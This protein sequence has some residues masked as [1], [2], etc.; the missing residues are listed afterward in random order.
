MK[1]LSI[2]IPCYNEEE[3]IQILFEKIKENVQKL[4][5]SYEVIFVDDG[6]TDQSQIRQIELYQK[7]PDNI[8]LIQ[9]RKNSGKA[10]ALAAGFR[11]AEGKL[12]ITMD[13]DLQDDPAEIKNLIAKINEG[14]DLVSGWK[15]KRHDPISKTL[16]SKIFNFVVSKLSGIKIHDFN[17][18]LKIYR[19]EVVE[20]LVV[21]GEMHRYLPVLAHWQ[22]FKISEIPVQHHPRQYGKSKYGF[23]RFVKG[24]LDLLTVLFLNRYAKR[25]LH[26]FG[27]IGIIL[28]ILGLFINVYIVSL[29][30][31]FGNIQNRHPL[32][33]LGILLMIISIQFISTGLLG[34]MFVKMYLTD[35]SKFPLKKTF[36]TNKIIK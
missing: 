2:V 34:E 36:G 19:R 20:T 29:W 23:A 24:F 17:C 1:D 26:F 15:K 10:A 13:A 12:I 4:K 27:T 22:G 35:E 8:K 7:Y 3:S 25:P 18:G 30:F 32:L 16:P 9:F 31:R 5:L 6:S 28:G 14:Y 11:E 21:Y 33:S